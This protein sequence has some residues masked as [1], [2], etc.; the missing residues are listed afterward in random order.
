M[1][2]DFVFTSESVTPGHPDKL[3]DQVSDAIV[4]CFLREDP[5]CRVTAESA[6]TKGILFLAVRFLTGAQVDVA[7]VARDVIARAGYTQGDFRA[8]TCSV[9]TNMMPENHGMASPQ[10][11]PAGAGELDAL[12]AEHNVTLF[13]FACRQS[14]GFL[15]LP[16]WLAH[17]LAR[18]L[19]RVR[20]EDGL[21]YLAPDGQAQVAVEYRGRRP[22]RVHSLTLLTASEAGA[23]VPLE[24]LRREVEERVVPAAFAGE[25]LRPDGKTRIYVNP[26]GLFPVGG[27]STH[28]GLT[29]RKTAI[30]TYGEYARHSGAALSGKDP[31]RIDR[32]GAYAA[33][34]A[35]KNVV[36]AGLA[37]ECEV[38]LSYA[39]GQAQPVS[40]Q[41]D[42]FGTG[43]LPDAEIA[44]RLRAEFDFRPAAVLAA[45]DL[46]ALPR[47]ANGPFFERLAVYG[48]VGR[49]D[50]ALP[51]EATDRVDAL[52]S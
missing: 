35:A 7:T 33:R 8:D 50:L 43:S 20:A 23:E 6:V 39:I 27:P 3:C 42:S 49:T 12:V 51:W 4:D 21:S 29:G 19:A 48:Q 40:L 11:M 30:D 24:R 45:F 13:G 5:A 16:V 22:H 36:A 34:H 10:R 14:P 37:E 46:R 2:G 9:M 38:Q 26:R 1:S 17:R 15:P 44:R 25:E 41:V 32:A 47:R 52:A 18:S 28:A 31:G